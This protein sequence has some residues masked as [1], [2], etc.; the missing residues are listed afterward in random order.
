MNRSDQITPLEHIK[1]CLI[2]RTTQL[3]A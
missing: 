1:Y 3:F 2:L